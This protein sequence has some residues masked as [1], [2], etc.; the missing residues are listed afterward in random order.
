MAGVIAASTT[1][2]C[3]LGGP[4]TDGPVDGMSEEYGSY[5][6]NADARGKSRWFYE[7]TRI[8]VKGPEAVR[9]GRLQ[10]LRTLGSVS[11]D[12]VGAVHLK[13]RMGMA[14]KGDWPASFE[15]ISGFRLDQHCSDGYDVELAVQVHRNSR[16]AGALDGFRLT[17]HV[18]D[19]EYEARSDLRIVLCDPEALSAGPEEL[20]EMCHLPSGSQTESP[21]EFA[22]SRTVG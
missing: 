18:G 11:V 10:P 19:R 20:E 8:C 15:P 17:Y 14:G 12:R 16:G 1:A 6:V 4:S 2:A 21:P 7:I 5:V 13:G 22:E 9:L 3:G